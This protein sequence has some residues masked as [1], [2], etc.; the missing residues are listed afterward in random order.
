MMER[1]DRNRGRGSVCKLLIQQET[2]KVMAASD[3]ELQI[4][5]VSHSG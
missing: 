1:V 3:F 5:K 4:P 2:S